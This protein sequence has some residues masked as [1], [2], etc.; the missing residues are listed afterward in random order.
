MTDRRPVDLLRCP[1]CVSALDGD[2][3]ATVRCE[4]GHAFDANRRGYL[5]LFPRKRPNVRGDTTAMLAARERVLDSAAYLALR[6]A[7][8][9]AVATDAPEHVVVADLGCGTGQY[10]VSALARLDDPA[11][12]VVA[13]LS[14]D[15]V[16][17][18]VRRLRGASVPVAVGVVLDLWSPLPLAS[19]AF[20]RVLNVFA[21]RNL[22]EFARILAPGGRLVTV[23]P[24]DD[25]L[26]E[27]RA[28]GAMIDVRAGKREQVL[29]DAAAAGLRLV[30]SVHVAG[31]LAPTAQLVDDLVAMG[32][33]AHH[34]RGDRPTTG[35]LPPRISTAVDVLVL[36]RA[37]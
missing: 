13:D 15:A 6:E 22:P 36:A 18:A 26:A 2:A 23:I 21:P 10:A 29:S 33:S 37:V 24:A 7:V 20:D 3:A 5:T 31:E 1:F 25:H 14:S 17:L 8:A 32:P 35:E 30:D 12:A 4:R 9:E 11:G 34:P 27:L 19:G 28:G 16:R